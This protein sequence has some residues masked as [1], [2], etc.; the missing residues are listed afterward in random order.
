MTEQTSGT[1]RGWAARTLA[2]ALTM[3]L[4]F[5]GLASQNATAAHAAGSG[6]YNS[7]L[8]LNGETYDGTA[9]VKEGDVLTLRFQYNA[10]ARGKTYTV[11][12]GDNITVLPTS[13][14][15]GNTAVQ[16]ITAQGGAFSV[17]FR[18]ADWPDEINQ[19]VFDLK[20]SVTRAEQGSGFEEIVWNIDGEQQPSVTVIVK[21]DGDEFENVTDGQKKTGPGNLSGYVT[22]TDGVVTLDPRAEL[23]RDYTLD[24]STTSAKPGLAIS[25]LLPAGMDYVAGSFA[26]RITSW[27][28]DGLN[29]HVEQIP[30]SPTLTQ[31]D[32]R[33]GFSTTRDLAANTQLRITYSAKITD[34]AAVQAQLQAAYD[35]L[36]SAS[37]AFSIRLTNT[38]AFGGV[39]ST[40]TF[41][42][43]GTKA[44][45]SNP[46]TGGE[47]A[48]SAV[49]GK[50]GEFVD[51]DS[52][53]RANV[54]TDET[55]KLK[56]PL[57]VRYS[58]DS[59]L[60][61]FAASGTLTTNAVIS[62]VLPAQMVWK[63][64][65]DGFIT[66]TDKATGAALPLSR[67]SDCPSAADFA[68][69][70]YANR[71]CVDGQRLLVNVGASTDRT[72]R[73]SALAQL[74]TI[75]G[76]PRGGTTTIQDAT[77]YLL[78]NTAGFHY[79][80]KTYNAYADLTVVDLPDTTGGVNDSTVFQKTGT[81]EQP[82]V[83]PGER[84]TVMYALRAKAASGAALADLTIVDH[85]DRSIFDLGDGLS[86]VDATSSY[87]SIPLAKGVDFSVTLEDRGLAFALTD[88]GKTKVAQAG[89]GDWIVKLTLQTRPLAK[90]E[91]LEI[92]NK[93]TLYGKDGR[94]THW[95]VDANREITSY[96]DEA[97]VRKRLFDRLGNGGAGEW[98]T[99]LPVGTDSSGRLLQDVFVYRVE[100]IPHGSYTE[101]PLVAVEDVLPAGVDFLGF[102]GEDDAAANDPGAIASTADVDLPAG[103]FVAS[104]LNGTIT[105]A[106]QDGTVI[107]SSAADTRIP[108]YFAVKVTDPRSQEKIVNRIGGS[109]A[110]ITPVGL[111]TT[112]DGSK[113]APKGGTVI[114]AVAYHG[115][116]PGRPYVLRGELMEKV[117]DSVTGEVTAKP[118]GITAER[119][120]SPATAAGSVD[121]GFTVPKGYAG[122]TLTVF[123]YLSVI[124]GDGG[125]SAVAEHADIHAV[126]QTVSVPPAVPTI[127]GEET[128][129]TKPGGPKEPGTPR[130]P[131][132][133]PG[134]PGTPGEPGG[135]LAV[136]GSNGV[137][138]L[139]ALAG[140]GMLLLGGGVALT[141]RRRRTRS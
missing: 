115:L 99:D 79:N 24:Y 126:E 50:S 63:S 74:V 119:A 65:A 111:G 41:A 131:S 42:I 134:Q 67:A 58:L 81:T 31:T 112:A 106:Q 10:D 105:I 56:A 128:P 49:F 54:E 98:V 48:G 113:L 1:T 70:A 92:T 139:L 114:D 125:E 52:A 82:V 68:A 47:P 130:Q 45:T 100:I 94:P 90:Q 64:G 30:F 132:E 84:G 32:G 103:K 12:F 133:K 75:E 127:P 51:A 53:K 141:A 120:F 77:A 129:P 85:V 66:A 29:K 91:T 20:F 4:A 37:G 140:A 38:A 97:E 34:L 61:K 108:L 60:D 11:G 43:S 9:V 13:V 136:T 22:V 117:T 72:V 19:G 27:D 88:A 76:L 23:V 121:V 5:F 138:A 116:E 6:I 18:D 101:V 86:L 95:S 89:A 87:G 21:E 15:A 3:L 122:K 110:T 17:Q 107:P 69:D 118:T 44:G 78:R 14:P 40:S 102:I 35:A 16:S 93:A 62:D 71:Y 104:Y 36:G 59:A 137:S 55:G 2:I 73:I 123:E 25:D 124:D 46:G 7:K 39:E 80:G 33:N 8:L 83:K 135:G 26:A 109:S 96:G 28:A 57:D